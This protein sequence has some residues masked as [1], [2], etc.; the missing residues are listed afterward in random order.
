[1][2][3]NPKAEQ[4]ILGIIFIDPSKLLDILDKVRESDFYNAK[5]VAIYKAMKALSAAG[6]HIDY[7]SVIER[8][9]SMD[10]SSFADFDYLLSLSEID[11]VVS[12]LETYVN[13]VID[14]SLKRKVIDTSN[15]IADQGFENNLNAEDY[16]GKAEELIFALAQGRKASEF[17]DFH[18]I[19][20]EVKKNSETYQN[21]KNGIVGLETGFHGLDKVTLGFKQEELIILAARPSIGKSA[22]AL[23][24]AVNIAKFN[25][26]RKNPNKTAKVAFFSLE[27]SNPQLVTRMVALESDI[28][29]D[30]I[31]KGQLGA[32]EWMSVT[33]AGESL[34]KLD[35]VFDDSASVGLFEIR[36]KCRQLSQSEGL[37]FIV[38][39]YLQLVKH[40][41]SDSKKIRSNAQNRQEEV[42]AVSRGLKQLA[43]EL[44]IPILA[45]AQLSRDVEKRENKKP[46]LADLR[47]SGSIEQDADIVMFLYRED[48]T[49]SKKARET[50]YSPTSFAELII[51]KNRQG[52]SGKDIEYSFIP[53]IFSFTE[54]GISEKEE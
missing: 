13:I 30:K 8:M 45:L 50:T 15:Q 42:A 46:T 48:A 34:G 47:E 53:G 3:N 41:D 2:P 44:K 12:H 43:R 40:I 28:S 54:I 4:A 37:D 39:D 33:A 38:I 11:P 1:M 22:L 20:S 10:L 18:E 52:A 35:I 25:A 32:S 23:N 31:Q 19:F 36:A 14:S 6:M 27:M 17:V 16:I 7:T 5:N 9:N 24:I 21:T 26:N 29:I 51:A 49:N